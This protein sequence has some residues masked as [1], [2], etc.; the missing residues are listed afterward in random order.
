MAKTEEKKKKKRPTAE[1]REIQNQKRR[2]QNRVFK[3]SVRT[4][5]R[6]F[7]EALKARDKESVQETFSKVYSMLD[8]GVKRGLISTHKAGRTKARAAA[9][10]AAQAS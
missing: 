7:D 5:L 6:T 2:L 10:V 9:Q 4:T 8:K 3:S 1:K